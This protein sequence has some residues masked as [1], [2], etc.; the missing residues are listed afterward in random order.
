MQF[1]ISC[2]GEAPNLESLPV[3]DIVDYPLEPAEYKPFAQARLCLTPSRLLVELWAFE[4]R[5]EPES[6]LRAVFFPEGNGGPVL[7]FQCWSG[8]RWEAYRDGRPVEPEVHPLSGE[9]LQGVYWGTRVSFP[10]S[11]VETAPG[12]LCPGTVLYGNLYKLSD[13]PRKPHQG[14]LFPADFAGGHPEAFP[15]MGSFQ[16]VSY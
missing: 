8:G 16:I 11:W 3:A 7:S 9:N 1:W 10:R 12:A 14:S 13:S 4:V 6:S 2:T 15:S 5:P